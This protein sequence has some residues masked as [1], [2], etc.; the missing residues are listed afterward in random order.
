MGIRNVSGCFFVVVFF[1]EKRKSIRVYLVGKSL[2]IA[3]DKIGI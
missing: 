3:L 2:I 1:V